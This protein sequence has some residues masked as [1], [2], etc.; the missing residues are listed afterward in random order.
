MTHF[1]QSD[2][3]VDMKKDELIF[4]LNVSC[5]FI[6]PVIL[7]YFSNINDCLSQNCTFISKIKKFTLKFDL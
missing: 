3:I 7:L 4:I 1:K 6:Y 2:V 5:A